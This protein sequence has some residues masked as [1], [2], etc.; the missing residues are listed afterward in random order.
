MTDFSGLAI[1]GR[2]ATPERLR[3]GPGARRLEPRGRPAAGG[4]RLRRE[5]RRRRR[6]GPL[7]RR[8]TA[9]RSPA[10][11]PATAPCRC[12]RSTGR[13][14]S[15]PSACAGS[16]STRG[17]DRPGRGGRALARAG[18]GG[19]RARAQLA[20]RL[21]ARRRRRRLHAR[22]RPQLARPPVRL[23]LQPRHAIELVTA[24]G[25][26]RTVDAEND[27]DL[28]WALRGGGGG[29]A[30]VTALHLA[31]VPI[32]EI[33][34]G[35]LIFPAELGADAF[36]AYRDWAASAPDEVTSVVRLLRPPP[37]P[38]V[39]EPL[40]GVPLLTIDAACIGEPR[41]GRGADRAAARD[42]RA[43]HGHL[44]PMPAAG[45]CRIHMDPE[46][47][48]PGLG[49]TPRSA[50]CPTRRSTPSSPTAPARGPA[51]PLLLAEL[52]QLGGALGRRSEGGGALDPPRRP[53]VMSAIGVADG[54]GAG[55]TVPRDL[56]RI[57]AGDG[58]L[59]RRGRL[60]Q[61]RRAPLRRRRDPAR[62]G[63]RPPRP[64]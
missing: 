51:R 11:A 31:L 6:D 22:R 54:A 55:E 37:I 34:A 63:L 61:L 64:R 45:L 57:D 43:D 27:P 14:C 28:F 35:V 33:Y 1:A 9:S 18:R 47:P 40:R 17:A 56:D 21:L 38:D 15:R 16:R 50:S 53:F 48:V 52:R 19:G 32:A 41:G 62:R 20:A 3:L 29:Y 44:R 49:A 24:D 60:L 2:V 4:R 42:R 10:R 13:S 58:A 59:G 5:R 12:R 39:P 7:R 26:Q 8:A 30:I 23:R 36:R 46:Q 25:E